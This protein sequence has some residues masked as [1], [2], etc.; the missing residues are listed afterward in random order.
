MWFKRRHE[1]VCLQSMIDDDGALKG[2]SPNED[3]DRE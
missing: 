1:S 3:G 2:D